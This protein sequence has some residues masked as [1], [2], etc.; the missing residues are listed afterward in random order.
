M[1][2][3]RIILFSILF[4]L[5]LCPTPGF[6]YSRDTHEV[7]NEEAV[8]TSVLVT[9]NYLNSQLGFSKGIKEEISGESDT[10]T[11][12]K[13]IK[14]GGRTEDEPRLR[15]KN[16]FH[17]PLKSWN[18]AGLSDGLSGRSSIIW[19]QNTNQSPGGRWSWQ[20]AREYYYLALTSATKEERD[21]NFADMFR[22]LGQVMHLIE[23]SSVPLHSRDDG[24]VLYNYEKWVK[25]ADLDSFLANPLFFNE[26]ILNEPPNSLAPIP[27][28]R[29]V[30]T[31]IYDGTNPGVGVGS[32]IG[33]SEYA[34]M[35]FL[36][37]YI[38][39]LEV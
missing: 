5:L 33:L 27:I 10:K 31:D 14:D 6:T 13:W 25:G 20:D 21:Q 19:A 4:S 38:K 12:E 35:N 29:I 22:A 28:A 34:N 3:Y 39:N 9:E 7:L 16:H 36:S 8:N 2:P 37:K 26:D 30:D 23:D 15:C 32:M 11:V 17:N 18:E 24:H 1:K